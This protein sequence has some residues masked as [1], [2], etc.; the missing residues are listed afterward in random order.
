LERRADHL[1]A[2]GLARRQGQRVTFARDLLTTL[3]NREL[4]GVAKGLTEQSGLPRHKPSEGEPVAGT[5]R[6]RLDLASG[7]FAMI[8][9]GL[10]FS[11]VPWTPQLERHRGQIVTGM[12]TPGG[13]IN[14]TLG[15]KRGLSL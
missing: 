6:Q 9:D 10:G 4:D 1:V 14:W 2:E 3:R 13:G 8:D 7:R 5:F 15:R 12:M 11:L